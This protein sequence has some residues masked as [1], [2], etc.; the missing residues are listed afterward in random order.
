MLTSLFFKAKKGFSSLGTVVNIKR[1]Y[2]EASFKEV[3]E[4]TSVA[5]KL[6]LDGRQIKT[7]NRHLLKGKN[8]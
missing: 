7:P 2:K 4:G 8:D 3:N 6:L 1:F 5:F